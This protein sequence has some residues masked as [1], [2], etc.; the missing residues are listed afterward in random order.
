MLVSG[1]VAVVHPVTQTFS[2]TIQSAAAGFLN[3]FL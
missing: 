1:A 2:R 3:G